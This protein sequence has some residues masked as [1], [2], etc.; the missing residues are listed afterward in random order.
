[1]VAH[2]VVP[3]HVR[4]QGPQ[5]VP[6]VHGRLGEVLDQHG[7]TFVG[8]DAGPQRMRHVAAQRV[9][10]AL[11]AV[12]RQRVPAAVGQPEPLVE[13]VAQAGRGGPPGGRAGGVAVQRLGEVR[14]GEVRGVDVALHLAQR[15]RRLGQPAGPVADRVEA[16]L[17]ALVGQAPVGGTAVLDE[18]V[19]VP[20]AVVLHP[21]QRLVGGRQQPAY[22]LR[23]AAPA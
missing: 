13:G 6:A 10:G 17:P 11:A 12:Q 15:D 1:M 23:V 8:G 4:R 7:G 18:P 9:D 3:R 2:R 19:A 5:P 21:G 14:A 22:P 16:V 20:V